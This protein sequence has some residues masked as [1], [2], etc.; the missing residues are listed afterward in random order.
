[1]ASY[2]QKNYIPFFAAANIDPNYPKGQNRS[3]IS[4]D[5]ELKVIWGSL[6]EHKFKV[7]S[8]DTET[9]GLNHKKCD[10]VGISIAF[11]RVNAIY[12]PIGHKVG[13]N[14]SKD[15]ALQFTAFVMKNS[16]KILFYNKNFDHRIL[17][18]A[19]ISKYI[20][21]DKIPYFD[22]CV[23][24][25]NAD[26]NMKYP[27]LKGSVLHYL[28]WKMKTFEEV[29]E[30][31]GVKNLD[32]SYNDPLQCYEYPCDDVLGTLNLGYKLSSIYK[33]MPFVCNI[34][35]AVLQPLKLMEDGVTYV[36][37]DHI[38][39][40]DIEYTKELSNLEMSIY[41]DI[42]YQFNLNSPKQVIEALSNVGI[43]PL[44]MTDKGNLSTQDDALEEIKD[45]HVVIK[46]IID[47]RSMRTIKSTFLDAFQR[48]YLPEEG[49][50]H[51]SYKTTEVPTGRLASGGDKKNS[52]FANMNGQNTPK[53]KSQLYSFN[54]LGNVNEGILGYEFFPVDKSFN[55]PKV[56]GFS[57]NMNIRSA[58][59]QPTGYLYF[60]VD[61]KAQELRLPTNFSKEPVWVDAFLNDK[62]LHT[63]MTNLIY[64]K[65]NF[66]SENRKKIK[67]VNFAAI[68]EGTK[69]AISKKLNISLDEA[70]S[71]LTSWWS[72]LTTLKKWSLSQQ[73]FGRK[74]GYVKTWF[75]RKRRLAYWFNSNN[76]RDIGFAERSCVNNPVQGTAADIMKIDLVKIYN[77]LNDLLRNRDLILSSTVH[78]EINFG[79]KR[80]K[81][82]DI[83][84]KILNIVDIK[85]PEWV[86]PMEVSMAIGTSWGNMFDFQ[87]VNNEYAP[88]TI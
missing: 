83:V 63:E 48:E 8:V 72:K 67:G 80:D 46:K 2:S 81:F 52:F 3:L 9:T 86:V 18:E 57:Q 7:I 29:L 25:F 74:H 17:H 65:E 31:D 13:N 68:Y 24:V 62:D 33:D 61:Y 70:D 15:L 40:L 66:S 1:M 77:E 53:P 23:L 75:G 38:K 60:H 69:Y 56:E 49:G 21:M 59:I 84:P 27:S 45:Q 85:I 43:K 37:I 47:Y 78:D 51:I 88:V 79:I 50:I 22:V 19:G 64:G 20:D 5:E 58:L 11:D 14:V 87:I 34:D 41:T 12:L 10:L 35:N 42:G 73:D 76:W 32:F 54:K 44:R 6:Q 55:G 71:I 4:S 39:K 30:Q 16:E 36:D 82:F 28:G 26:S